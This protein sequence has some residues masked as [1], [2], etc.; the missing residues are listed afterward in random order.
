MWTKEKILN[1][2]QRA[3][4]ENAGRP[5]GHIRFEKETGL[6]K[7]DWLKYWPRFTDA[8]KE[9]GFTPNQLNSAYDDEFIIESFIALIRKLKKIPS[10]DEVRFESNNNSAF[11]TRNTFDRFGIK[12]D[13]IAKI[14]E[15]YQKEN[16]YEDVI[17]L[18][19]D[20]LENSKAKFEKDIE[21]INLPQ[22]GEVYLYK[23][24]KHY[25][26]GASKDTVRRGSELGSKLPEKLEMIHII[27]TDDP[28]GIEKYWHNR[29][30]E[31]R[32]NGE[33]FNLKSTDIKAFKRWRKII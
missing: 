33:W 22:V 7:S 13:L 30:K 25:K 2:I 10:W 24:G 19:R 16:K 23:S 15:S 8:Q 26:I 27:S 12:K 31:K 14:I 20:F 28:F 18:C 4:K 11:P 21:E 6:R 5:L 3:A 29:F 17:K 32:L 1:E 9:A